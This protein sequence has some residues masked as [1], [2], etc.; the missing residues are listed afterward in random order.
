MFF[1]NRFQLDLR[2]RV[3]YQ[4]GWHEKC[5]WEINGNEH[6]K[7]VRTQFQQ[8]Y[9]VNFIYFIIIVPFISSSRSIIRNKDFFFFIFYQR[10]VILGDYFNILELPL[11]LSARSLYTADVKLPLADQFLSQYAVITMLKKKKTV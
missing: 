2:V 1:S 3:I 9:Q 7:G 8:G 5:H 10:P 6:F 4:R 11:Y